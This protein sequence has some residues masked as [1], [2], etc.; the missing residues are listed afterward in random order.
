MEAN[1][2]I[3]D[4]DDT[5]IISNSTKKEN[6]FKVNA[7]TGTDWNTNGTKSF[8]INNQQ[9][10]LNLAEIFLLCIFT[11][12]KAATNTNATLVNDFFWKMFDSVRLYIGTQ[13]VE[14]V[15]YVS[16][17]SE[18]MKF[19]LYSFGDRMGKG[20]CRRFYS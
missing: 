8:E 5:I 17:A 13:E 2:G 7:I 16:A 10:Y 1:D 15:D 6:Y 20:G 18:M 3:Y 11:F 9:T 14:A 12:T 19:P 4:L